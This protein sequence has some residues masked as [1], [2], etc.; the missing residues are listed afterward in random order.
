MMDV[1]SEARQM[2]EYP[3]AAVPRVQL[4]LFGAEAGT[5]PKRPWRY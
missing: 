2:E 1:A 3:A 4:R 5:R